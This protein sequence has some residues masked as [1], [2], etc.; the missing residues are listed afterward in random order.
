MI[1]RPPRST[2]CPYT[3]LF[4]SY[5]LLPAVLAPAFIMTGL[6]FHQV[7]LVDSKG[8]SLAMFAT[9]FV[10]YAGSTMVSALGIGAFIDRSSATRMMHFH[11]TPMVA[12]LVVL[13]SFDQPATMF[14]YMLLAGFSSG[15]NFTVIGAVWAELYGEI[16]RAHV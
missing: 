9:G 16:G 13:A 3:P 8:W 1:R 4:R 7:H 15:A 5:L 10:V 14:V 11:L 12:G 2:L 6:M